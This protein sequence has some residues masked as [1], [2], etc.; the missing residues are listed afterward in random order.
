MEIYNTIGWILIT[1]V[2][3]SWVLI[4]EWGWVAD[5]RPILALLWGIFLVWRY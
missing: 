2:V 3:T 4:R 1:T 5:I